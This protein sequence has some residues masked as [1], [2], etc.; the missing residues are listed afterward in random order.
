LKS[1]SS[2]GAPAEKA[3]GPEFK[4]QY[5]FKKKKNESWAQSWTSNPALRKLRQENHKFEA[6]LGYT[7][8][9]HVKCVVVRAC[10]F[11]YLGN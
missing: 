10:G 9:Y 6:S 7:A 2:G 11:S 8:R 3:Q 5:H 1:A 4:P